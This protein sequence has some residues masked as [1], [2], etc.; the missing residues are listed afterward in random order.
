MGGIT[1]AERYIRENST[2]GLEVL[3]AVWMRQGLLDAQSLC[4]LGRC[5]S[6]VGSTFT[7]KDQNQALL[8]RLFGFRVLVDVESSCRSPVPEVMSIIWSVLSDI[9]KREA[10]VVF[11][12]ALIGDILAR[13]LV[14]INTTSGLAESDRI[15]ALW[16]RVRTSVDNLVNQFHTEIV[17]LKDT[18][19][20]GRAESAPAQSKSTHRGKVPRL[21]VKYFPGVVFILKVAQYFGESDSELESL[22]SMTSVTDL[23]RAFA[24]DRQSLVRAIVHRTI[25]NSYMNRTHFAAIWSLLQAACVRWEVS[26]RKSDSSDERNNVPATHYL[27]KCIAEMASGEEGNV[28]LRHLAFK[29]FIS[30]LIWAK[31]GKAFSKLEGEKEG[32][33][34]RTV[35]AFQQYDLNAFYIYALTSEE[36]APIR[37]HWMQALCHTHHCSNEMAV[38]SVRLFEALFSDSVSMTMESLWKDLSSHGPQPQQQQAKKKRKRRDSGDKAQAVLEESPPVALLD[39]IDHFEE[40]KRLSRPSNTIFSEDKILR[41][42][43]SSPIKMTPEESTSIVQTLRNDVARKKIAPSA[44]VTR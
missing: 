26:D 2:C 20:L 4:A 30:A 14:R 8:G 13:T 9:V 35:R 18:P 34:S 28:T 24:K 15:G 19:I 32:E 1:S 6:S 12:G 31:A 39:I 17:K 42:L 23:L 38:F 33:E 44:A 36:T 27:L 29:Q 25:K 40:A 11:G 41:E 22:S 21:D 3:V 37:G 16:S 7:T 43:F 5:I 10:F